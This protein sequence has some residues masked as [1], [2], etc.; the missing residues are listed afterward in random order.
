[1]HFMFQ[2]REYF[3]SSDDVRIKVMQTVDYLCETLT[4][5]R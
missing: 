1:M 3:S 4:I 2:E 5:D